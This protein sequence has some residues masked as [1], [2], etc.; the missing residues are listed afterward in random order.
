MDSRMP[1]NGKPQAKLS[2]A[3][4]SSAACANAGSKARA[5]ALKSVLVIYLP[6]G[7]TPIDKSAI[8][9][10]KTALDRLYAKNGFRRYC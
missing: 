10:A 4:S 2:V 8:A 1:A 7:M 6:E 3:P 5:A 9:C